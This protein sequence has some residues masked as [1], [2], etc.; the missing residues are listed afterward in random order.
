MDLVSIGIVLAGLVLVFF[1]AALSIYSVALLGFILGGGAAYVVA[2]QF[3]GA[4]GAEGL[5]AV[6]GVVLV[7]ALLGA[8]FGYVALSFATAVPAFVVGSYLGLYAL[9][10]LLTDGGAIGYLV[11][12][13]AG[14]V[15]AV[16]GFA[17]T[18]FAL[19]VVTAFV[20]AALA[21]GA[22]TVADLAA[23]RTSFSPEPLL[24]DPLVPLFG[25]LFAVGLAS[26]VGLFRLGWA[27]RLSTLLPGIGRVTGTREKAS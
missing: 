23:A 21:S 5:A 8:A 12:V 20:G 18:K 1:G 13:V 9:A 27:T 7:G 16:L 6:A 2:P 24:F 15:G 4:A 10:P 19:M 22:V 26:Q 3:L 14:V 25:A 17:L 11:M